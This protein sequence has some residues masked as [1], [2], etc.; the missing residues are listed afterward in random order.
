MS[1]RILFTRADGK[2]SVIVPVDDCGLT[3]DEIASRVVPT[4]VYHEVVSASDVPDDRTFRDAWEHDVSI[5]AK[6]IKTNIVKAKDLAHYRRR[7]DRDKKMKPLD[8]MATIPDKAVAVE[9]ER[10]SIRESN[11]AVQ[12]AIDDSIAESDIKEALSRL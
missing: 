12:V 1:N 10:Q 8:V 5:S 9:S 11:H 6:K 3:I 4:G 2:L 7:I